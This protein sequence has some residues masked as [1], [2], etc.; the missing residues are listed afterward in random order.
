MVALR[1]PLGPDQQKLVHET[2][3]QDDGTKRRKQQEREAHVRNLDAASRLIE[4]FNRSANAFKMHGIMYRLEKEYPP[5]APTICLFRRNRPYEPEMSF[6][7]VIVGGP[8]GTYSLRS[9]KKQERRE[10][11]KWVTNHTKY[12]E[13]HHTRLSDDPEEAALDI[14]TRL[15]KRKLEL[16]SLWEFDSTMGLCARRY[17]ARRRAALGLSIIGV[18]VLATTF[19]LWIAQRN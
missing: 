1:N 3:R 13:E 10:T 14:I 5:F 2:A 7:P 8:H 15:T 6:I 19:M 9:L 16:N 4:A 18:I 11:F 17:F 12:Y